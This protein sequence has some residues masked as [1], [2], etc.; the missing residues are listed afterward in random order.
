MLLHCK[1]WRNKYC[2]SRIVEVLLILHAA[3]AFKADRLAPKFTVLSFEPRNGEEL[4]R[5]DTITA[6]FSQAVIAL[7]EDLDQAHQQDRQPFLITGIQIP[8]K[9]RWVTTSIARLDPLIDWPPGAS[10]EVK[11]NQQLRSV[12]GEVLDTAAGASV[13]RTYTTSPLSL[14]VMTVSSARANALTKEMWSS[15]QDSESIP[16]LGA[17]ECPPDALVS[18]LFSSKVDLNLLLKED[19]ATKAL[20]IFAINKNNGNNGIWSG[21]VDDLNKPLRILGPCEGRKP[22]SLRL[23]PNGR[24]MANETHCVVCSLGEAPPL[25]T[26]VSYALRMMPGVK[27]HPYANPYAADAASTDGEAP[28]PL[29]GF[30]MTLTGLRPFRIIFSIADQDIQHRRF[31]IY[32]RHGLEQPVEQS[33]WRLGKAFSLTNAET[34]QESVA[35]L[36]IK[37]NATLIVDAS[38]VEPG[39]RYKLSIDPARAG[40]TIADGFGQPLELAETE[41]TMARSSSLFLMPRSESGFDAFDPTDVPTGLGKCG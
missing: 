18:V 26:G 28:K 4:E 20:E 29:T 35:K 33:V 22:S 39:V 15:L 8:W 31:K 6:V 34:H 12:F 1:G 17:H 24:I 16:P 7:G 13:S 38:M 23:E 32:L 25:Q 3:T 9:I 30:G 21:A 40:A 11:I 27:F 37:G 5:R 19:M 10:F 36:H 2:I 14:H 41:F